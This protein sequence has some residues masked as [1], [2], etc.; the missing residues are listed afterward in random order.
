MIYFDPQEHK[1]TKA[2]VHYLSV[3]QVLQNYSKKFNASEE[4]VGMADRHGHSPEY[5]QQKWQAETD[6]SLVIGDNL[7]LTQEELTL[8]QAFE[9]KNGKPIRVQNQSLFG[10]QYD[11]WYWPDGVYTELILWNDNYRLAGRADKIVMTTPQA[12]TRQ[13]DVEDYKSNKRIRTYGWWEKDRNDWRRMLDP[14]SHLIDCEHSK[15]A[16]QLSMYQFMLEGIGFIPGNRKLLHY[17]PL[18]PE[19]G[20]PGERRGRPDVYELPYLRDEVLAIL[21]H[22]ATEV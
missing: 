10:D 5:W 6:R 19:L 11:Y 20:Y 16:L 9:I 14:V 7:H 13:A 22:H 12:F 17:P 21:N 1:Y 15:Y 18:P 8:S 2:G 3:T 4:A